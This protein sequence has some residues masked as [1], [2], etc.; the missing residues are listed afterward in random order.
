M[1][2]VAGPARAR[3]QRWFFDLWS[4]FYDLPLVQRA[5]YRPEQ[6]AVLAVLRTL[7]CRTV[8]D[9]GCG[10]GQLAHRIRRELPATRVAGCDF[11]P[12][13]LARAAARNPGGAWVRGDALSLPFRSASLDAVVS[14]EAFHWFPNQCAAL[15][16]VARTLRPGGRF[17]VTIVTPP[18]AVV[19]H[20]AAAGSRLLGQP[21]H[22]PT[23]RALRDALTAAGFEV[24]HQRYLLR[25]PGALLL[26]PTLTVAQRARPHC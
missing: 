5:V 25:F 9:L 2:V 3:P 20:L 1:V 21:F 4:E 23:A 7:S 6:D 18:L 16:E 15:A 19:S 17:L 11:S 13:M 26:P 8:L 14:T 24:E 22:W 10:T 12:G